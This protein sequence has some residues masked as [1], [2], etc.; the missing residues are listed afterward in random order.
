MYT[1][2]Q[3]S[4]ISGVSV[5]TLHHYDSIG[6]L[7]PKAVTNAGYRFYDEES[8]KR[9]Q[10]I[11]LFRELEFSLKEIGAILDNPD[12]DQGLALRQQI[13]LLR[14]KRE[15]L[16][17]IIAFARELLKTGVDCMDFKSF[18]RQDIDLY[19][20][21][22]KEKWGGTAAYREF[23]EKAGKLP[24]ARQ[25]ELAREMLDIFRRI[26]KAKTLP[27]N[28]PQAQSLVKEL[29]EFISANYYTCT[30]QI[31][32]GLAQMYTEDPRM[33]E[34]IDQAGGPGTAEFARRAIEASPKEE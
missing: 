9:L 3:V 25:Q 31:L 5:R 11:L 8:L 28:S 7:R 33:R 12:F 2:S 32:Q 13:E 14:L 26:G 27:P 6:L 24:E 17:R 34:N 29:R 18:D 21:E 10:S 23:Q 4:K 19:T 16:D 22:A 20:K 1:V 30:S 15:R